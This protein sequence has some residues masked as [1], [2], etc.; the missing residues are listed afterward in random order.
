MSKQLEEMAKKNR[1]H[2]RQNLRKKLNKEFQRANRR[3]K[4]QYY[5]N[6]WKDNEDEN[7]HKKGKSSRRSPN[8][9]DSNL[10]LA[11]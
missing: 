6:I 5:N 9:R 7:R 4:K 2:E 11:C 3:D 10:E 8:L 1:R